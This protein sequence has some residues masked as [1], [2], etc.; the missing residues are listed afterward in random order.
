MEIYV[1]GSAA[2]VPLVT[3]YND[4]LKGSSVGVKT[5]GL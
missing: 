5:L 1:I 2:R 3:R 4:A